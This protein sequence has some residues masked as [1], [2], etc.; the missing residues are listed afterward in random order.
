MARALRQAQCALRTGG[1]SIFTVPIREDTIID[2]G[3]LPNREGWLVE[4][5]DGTQDL[6]R[7]VRDALTHR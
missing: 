4:L 5:E 3:W 7:F 2:A 1:I 6:D